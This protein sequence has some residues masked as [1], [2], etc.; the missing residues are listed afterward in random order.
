LKHNHTEHNDKQE[1]LIFGLGQF[2]RGLLKELSREWRVTVVDL[3]EKRIE[4]NREEVPA[5]NYIHGAAESLITWKKLELKNIKYI[6]SAVRSNEVDLAVC[7]IA[8]DHYKLKIPIIVLVYDEVKES[9]FVEYHATIVNPLELGI[10]VV[11]QKMSTHVSHAHN[12]GLGTGELIEVMVKARSHLVDRKLKYLRPTRW[13]ISALY[14]NGQLILPEGNC[15]IKIGDRVLLVGNPTV[16]QNVSQTLLKGLPHFP[17][18]YGQEISFPLH[19]DFDSN[20]DEAIYWFNSFKASNIQFIPFKKQLSP[21]AK[22]KIKTEVEKF[23]IGQPI[24]RFRGIFPLQPETGV[25]IIPA[26]QGWFKE[27][28]IRRAFKQSTKPFLLSRKS[29]P[30][31]GVIIQ[32]NGP[33]P[34]QAM[35]TGVEIARMLNIPY[36]ALYVTFP[37]AMRGQDEARRLQLRRQLVLDYEGIYKS[38]IP[39]DVMEG[40]PVRVSINF[41]DAYKNFLMVI[42]TNP[43]HSLSFF[44]P[45]APYHIARKAG[46]ST[47]V[48]PETLNDE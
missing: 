48:I 34:T 32:L 31:E 22:E 23:K 17:L 44:K 9:H 7:R 38:S 20:M 10:Q 6:I 45:N 13:H 27:N 28:R 19:K 2:A 14:R 11:L 25:V 33:D 18:Q 41:L 24:E 46:L 1:V 36:R 37:K 39:Y 43:K 16:L 3:M 8:R 47:L 15:S 40:N 12:V 21:I 29:F 30:Y 42:V 35:E 4:E 5:A 26:D